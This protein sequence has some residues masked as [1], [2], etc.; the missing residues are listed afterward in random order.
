MQMSAL[1]SP[2]LT[3]TET[4][5]T[6]ALGE[7]KPGPEGRVPMHMGLQPHSGV[8]GVGGQLVGLVAAGAGIGLVFAILRHVL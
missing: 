4:G 2:S 3:N 8:A 7:P 6:T 1:L 5:E